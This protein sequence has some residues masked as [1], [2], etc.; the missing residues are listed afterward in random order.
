MY[1]RRE[2]DIL[3]LV[4]GARRWCYSRRRG[5]PIAP[6]VG[7]NDDDVDDE[8]AAATADEDEDEDEDGDDVSVMTRRWGRR[9]RDSDKMRRPRRRCAA[10]Q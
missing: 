6:I 5:L 4:I 8:A 2:R 9:Q 3:S 1:H 7:N 10:M